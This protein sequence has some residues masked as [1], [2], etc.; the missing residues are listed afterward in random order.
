MCVCPWSELSEEGGIGRA[1]VEGNWVGVISAGDEAGEGAVGVYGSQKVPRT[2]VRPR[3]WARF[4]LE[5]RVG[6]AL[7]CVCIC[8]CWGRV[9]GVSR[10]VR[11]ERERVR[12]GRARPPRWPRVGAVAAPTRWPGPEGSCGHLAALRWLGLG[13]ASFLPP[14]TLPLGPSRRCLPG[15]PLLPS[16][17]ENSWKLLGGSWE[18]RRRGL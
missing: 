18:I 11:H 13:V 7:A 14:P 4:S 6:R 12:L 8:V 9:R 1:G 15:P 3:G 10:S 2:S 17:V 16:R 5:A